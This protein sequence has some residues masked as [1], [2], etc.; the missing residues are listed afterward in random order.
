MGVFVFSGTQD[1]FGK[2]PAAFPSKQKRCCG[3]SKNHVSGSE[4]MVQPTIQTWGPI[5]KKTPL[6]ENKNSHFG[7]FN[8]EP[9]D[10]LLHFL[11]E[12]D[13]GIDCSGQGGESR[14]GG[15]GEFSV[16]RGGGSKT[17]RGA[18]FLFFCSL[19]LLGGVP[20]RTGYR[21]AEACSS[22]L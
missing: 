19:F 18:I 17:S 6:G 2:L 15:G 8:R 3:S 22:F 20:F 11:K 10:R 14:A 5:T 16:R 7:R 13:T 12:T 1:G 9:C 4:D 21:G